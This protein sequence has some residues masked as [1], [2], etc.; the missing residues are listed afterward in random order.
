MAPLV[1][2]SVA[3]P[4]DVD[5]IEAKKEEYPFEPHWHHIIVLLSIHVMGL[6]GLVFLTKAKL[7]TLVF[8]AILH[9]VGFLGIT[10]GAHRLWAH[11]SYKATLPLRLLLVS[12]QSMTPQNSV[13]W[14]SLTHRRHHKNSDTDADPHNIHRGFFFAHLGWLLL[15]KHPDVTLKGRTV[16]VSDLWNDPVLAFQNRYYLAMLFVFCFAIPTVI[17]WYFWDEAILNAFFVAGNLRMLI[18]LHASCLVNSAA[19]TFGYKPYDR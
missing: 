16:D 6:Y 12:M 7:G 14:W 4:R 5:K 19:H 1:E 17:P 18:S 3:N 11:R 9:V 15:K 2:P 13:I 10:A 8:A